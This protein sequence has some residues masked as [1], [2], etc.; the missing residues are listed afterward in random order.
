MRDEE[1]P[2]EEAEYEQRVEQERA[3]RAAEKAPPPAEQR[4]ARGHLISALDVAVA[5]GAKLPCGC[6]ATSVRARRDEG[7]PRIV[8]NVIE[9]TPE[10]LVTSHLE[11]ACLRCGAGMIRGTQ[12]RH[13]G[14]W[15]R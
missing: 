9:P 14:A 2:V 12:C 7:L 4:C 1:D 8:V 15:C 5:R 11:M 13:C 3:D 6:P 10:Q